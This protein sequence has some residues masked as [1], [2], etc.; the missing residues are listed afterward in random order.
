[1]IKNSTEEKNH[2]VQQMRKIYRGSRTTRLWLG[3]GDRNVNNFL[4]WTAG[5]SYTALFNPVNI[6]S[7][8]NDNHTW[9]RLWIVQ[10]VILSLDVQVYVSHR[11]FS[12]V[13]FIRFCQLV[14]AEINTPERMGIAALIAEKLSWSTML[15]LHRQRTD[16]SERS[17]P[18]LI[19][20][21]CTCQ[22]FDLRD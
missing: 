12:W 11:D 9:T 17:F 10:E 2:Q 20:N 13:E 19:R 22:C 15:S 16:K 21:Y 3:Q 14:A 6:T 7:I 5:Y 18:D 8:K 4:R 1:L